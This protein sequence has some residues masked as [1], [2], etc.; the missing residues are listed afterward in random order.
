METNL[1]FIFQK[2]KKYDLSKEI[3]EVE[4][5]VEECDPLIG[6]LISPQSK[7]TATVEEDVNEPKTN[8]P[9]VKVCKFHSIG[10]CKRGCSCAYYHPKQDCKEHNESG[11]CLNSACRDRH[12]KDCWFYTSRKGCNNV[13]K[14]SFLHREQS[15]ATKTGEYEEKDQ[16][17]IKIFYLKKEVPKKIQK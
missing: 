5:K 2:E 1:C 8:E 12:R 15:K 6:L 11:M 7:L 14:C 17:E 3:L 10:F 9:E 16:L 13:A 4:E